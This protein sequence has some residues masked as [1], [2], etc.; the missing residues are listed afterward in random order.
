[1][2]TFNNTQFFYGGNLGFGGIAPGSFEDGTASANLFQYEQNFTSDERS[3]FI[4]T[5][6]AQN[7]LGETL[8]HVGTHEAYDDAAMASALNAIYVRQGIDKPKKFSSRNLKE[9]TEASN[10]WHQ[11]LMTNCSMKYQ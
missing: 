1:M 7:A 10:Y 3:S 5:Q 9:M 4:L 2:V 6:T 8:H 11:P